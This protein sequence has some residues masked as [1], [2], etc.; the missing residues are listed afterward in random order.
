MMSC[1]MSSGATESEMPMRKI[2]LQGKYSTYSHD[3]QPS[4]NSNEQHDILV[5]SRSCR[6][7]YKS[8]N[9]N[10]LSTF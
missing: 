3:P 7:L 6:S 1:F 2:C 5:V 9:L 10:L 8:S 4:V